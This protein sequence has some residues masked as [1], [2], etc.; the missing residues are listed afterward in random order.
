MTLGLHDV[1]RSIKDDGEKIDAALKEFEERIEGS[2]DEMLD[3]M[4]TECKR[5]SERA[6]M[7]ADKFLD[8]A[9][10]QF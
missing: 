8:A 1:S 3:N 7:V 2:K 9:V 5:L 6:A 10:D 4:Y